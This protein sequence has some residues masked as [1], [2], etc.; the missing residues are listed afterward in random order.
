MLTGCRTAGWPKVAT[1]HKKPKMSPEEETHTFP[2]TCPSVSI[3]KWRSA[4]STYVHASISPY[5][6]SLNQSTQLSSSDQMTPDLCSP[7]RTPGCLEGWSA[8]A[9]SASHSSSPDESTVVFSTHT[10]RRITEISSLNSA[11]ICKGEPSFTEGQRS[12]Q[13]SIIES[14]LW[15]R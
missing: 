14:A 2:V 9:C 13:C 3:G 15:C 1:S 12:P 8:S 7:L 10:T 6:C 4:D 5:T 11:Y